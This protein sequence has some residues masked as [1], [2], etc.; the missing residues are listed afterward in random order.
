M[1]LDKIRSHIRLDYQ[2]IFD[3]FGFPKYSTQA[4]VLQLYRQAA[5]TIFSQNDKKFN[6]FWRRHLHEILFFAENHIDS[7]HSSITNQCLPKNSESRINHLS[8]VITG[9]ILRKSRKWHQHPRWHI[10]HWEI[11]WNFIQD[12]KEYFKPKRKPSECKTGKFE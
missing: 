6:R 9:D 11:Q 1:L 10:Y 7:L 2:Y 3:E 8:A 4:I 12:I 5:W